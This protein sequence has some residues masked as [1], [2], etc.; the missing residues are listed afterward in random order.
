MRARWD[1]APFSPMACVVSLR[2]YS[3][4]SRGADG[5]AQVTPLRVFFRLNH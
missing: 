3:F 5:Q 2:L 1:R 4:M